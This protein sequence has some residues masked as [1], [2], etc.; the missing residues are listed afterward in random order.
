MSV[1]TQGILYKGCLDQNVNLHVLSDTN[2]N[3]N[4][5]GSRSDNAVADC[6]RKKFHCMSYIF[7]LTN[8]SV[9]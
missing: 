7:I 5:C 1:S 8:G 2:M 9:V 3:H 4:L 6:G